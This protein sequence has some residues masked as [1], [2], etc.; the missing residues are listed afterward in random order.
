LVHLSS[1]CSW[2]WLIS[3]VSKSGKNWKFEEA[4]NSEIAPSKIVVASAFED[5]GLD[6]DKMIED[7][8]AFKRAVSQKSDGRLDILGNPERPVASISSFDM[9]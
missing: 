4:N 5:T 8:V 1:S 3:L 9:L 2:R 6:S 7:C